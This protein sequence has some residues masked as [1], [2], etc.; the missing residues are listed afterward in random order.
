[1]Q[2]TSNNHNQEKISTETL[3]NFVEVYKE[4]SKRRKEQ[5]KAKIVP[6]L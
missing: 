4:K 1:M 3:N 5:A 6:T 2:V